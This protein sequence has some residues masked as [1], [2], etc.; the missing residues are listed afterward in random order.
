MAASTRRAKPTPRRPLTRRKLAAIAAQL[1]SL[2]T[3]WLLVVALGGGGLVGVGIAV[4]LE[5]LLFEGKRAVLGGERGV[6][7]GWVCI[8]A[9]GL[10]NAGGL[11]SVV[12][13]FDKTESYKMLAQSLQL[14][15]EMRLIPALLIALALG[16]W[17]SLAPHD[18][19]REEA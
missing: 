14:G 12:L 16:V 10:I 18:L 6:A 17:L 2:Y 11:W 7:M 8:G 4:L 19:W 9:D 1:A 5:W 3:T 15:G 13:K